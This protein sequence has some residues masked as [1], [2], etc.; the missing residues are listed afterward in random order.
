MTTRSGKE[1]KSPTIAEGMEEI[2]KALME[3]R[4]RYEEDERARRKEEAEERTRREEIEQA[5][6]K[7]E[8]EEQARRVQEER[9]RREEIE[10]ARR[11]E[12]AGERARLEEER[13]IREQQFVLERREMQERME[14]LVRLVK[15]PTETPGGS[16]NPVGLSV[17]LASLSEK[18]DIEAYLVTFER[19]MTAQ[20]VD[21]GRWSQF[22][23]PQLTGRAQLAF[24]ALPSESAA[25]YD[26]IKAAVLA[27][28]DIN[29]EA[30]RKRFR[31]SSRSDGETNREVAVR[32][33]DLLQ[34]WTK[35]CKTV[36]D[37]Q[38]FIGKEQFLET[39]SN[40]EQKLWVMEK[41]PKTSIAAGELA[42]EYEQARQPGLQKARY[43]HQVG[44][45]KPMS[46]TN[47]TP[48]CD[49]CGL[50]GHME[51]EC[52][53]KAST[54]KGGA[55][56]ARLRCFNCK[57][58]GHVSRE[59]PEK[60][61]MCFEEADITQ[62]GPWVAG[63]VE[64]RKVSRILLDTGCTRTMV[65]QQWVP[66]EKIIDGKMVSIRCA[67]G[68]TKL[69]NL[70]DLILHIRGVPVKVEAAVAERLPV[71]V[72]LG[73]DVPELGN[74]IRDRTTKR[75]KAKP[76]WPRQEDVMVVLTRARARQQLE[77]E[78]VRRARQ[79]RSGVR[80][81]AIPE[82]GQEQ[83]RLAG[84]IAE[85]Q[86][87]EATN[88]EA[89]IGPAKR[90]DSTDL[91]QIVLTPDARNEVPGEKGL[92]ISSRDLGRSQQCD[93]SLREGWEK[94]EQSNG[95]NEEFFKRDGLL[96]R[97]WRPPGRSE[98]YEWEQ[99]VLPKQCRKT[100]LELAH[101][102]PMA[103]HQGRDKTRQRI[104]RRFYW[105]SLF[106]DTEMYCKSC[107]VCQK[108][109]KRGV[110]PAPL[111]PLPVISEPFSRVAMDIVGPLP[112]SQA[113]NRYILVVCD[114]AT[115]YPEAIPLRTID[116]EHI[117]E[118]L[119]KLFA[120][121]GVP[122]E[123]L[124]DQGSNFMSQLL[125]ELYRLLGVKAI[126]TSPYHPQ[127]DGL[128]ERFNQ[129]LKGMLRKTAHDG[130]KYWDKQIPYLLFA[131][132]E[133]PQSSTGFSPFE[134]LYGRDVRGPLDIL[135]ETWEASPK[136]EET[137]V[138]HVLETHAQQRLK[139]MADI[140]EENLV[141][142]Q[143]AQ[144]QW[145]DKRARLREFKSGDPVLVLLPTTTD[146]L[147]A[148]WQGPYQVLERKGKV[149]YSVDMHDKRKRTRVFHVNMLK[150]FQV[151][152]EETCFLEEVLQEGVDEIPAWKDDTVGEAH[153]G[154][155]LS[156][157]QT[158]Q[159][160][161]VMDEFQEIFS[162]RPGRTNLMQHHIRTVDACPVRMRPYRLPHAYRETVLQE[163]EEMEQHGIIEQSTSEW[164]SPIVLVK[165]KD[166]TMRVCVDYRRLNAVTQ[167]E[168]YPMPRIDE[169]ID[170]LGKARYIS[171]LDLTKGYWQMPVAV[172]DRPKTA[173]V[174]P[175]GLFQFRVMPF[176]LN[177]APA[178]FQR[179]TDTLVRGCEAF[180]AA[181]LDDVVIYSSTWRGHIEHLRTVLQRIKDAN[182][183]VKLAKC[184]FGMKEC[185][186]LG[187]VVGNGTVRPE[188]NKIGA[189]ESFP[190]P[191]T[192]REVRGFL[193]LTGY[194]RRFIPDYATIALPL[195]DLTRRTSPNVVE[196]NEECTKAFET[197][198]RCLCC[199][200]VLK[201]PDFTQPFVLQTDASDRGAGAVL[202][203]HGADGEEHPVAYY[204]R[205]FLPREE[206]YS[207]VEKE[208]LAIKLAIAAFR[209]YLLGRRFTI[210]TDHRSLEWLDK[211][212]ESNPRLCR[213]SLSLQP[214][215][216]TVEHRP[217][218]ANGNAD[219]LSRWATNKFVVGEEERSVEAQSSMEVN[220]T[221]HTLN[222]GREQ[223][224]FK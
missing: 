182:L 54:S 209:V 184:Q 105:P 210:Q 176:G 146:K 94:A 218:K 124:T 101:D 125:A 45:Q 87:H 186:Y 156:T 80:P 180:A 24:A 214:Y 76:A 65:R 36:D 92:N 204:S 44:T 200:P 50:L 73:T 42:D 23:T 169:I 121:V 7:E 46:Q 56:K 192:K 29:E 160:K 25:D 152:S 99:L 171:T 179:L 164:S 20:K 158:I 68:D 126:R 129:T 208:C 27:R 90:P 170:Q 6:R 199:D 195:T 117:A 150:A 147:T 34:K 155:Q 17:K 40:P 223:P 60:V 93:P 216:Y 173:F 12:E 213:W 135:R 104:L 91:N 194:Y 120:R 48:R 168:A 26:A 39:L 53:K 201:S 175:R 177:G 203:Q 62:S 57:K 18:D 33:M 22:L 15:T 139:E 41:K 9:Q 133:V 185:V 217:G 74:L 196:W 140:V 206:R 72:I 58:Q 69:Y 4:R 75:D 86:R 55:E 32:L 118:E 159:M 49:Y 219:C 190:R 113:G 1:Y 149:T 165:K 167:V 21:K 162:N 88:V 107:R 78:M 161:G 96:Y 128:V 154:E 122:K 116:A 10:Q 136:S 82:D 85:G 19:I 114:Y 31:S 112:R 130:G 109:S 215:L 38:Q 70:A 172:K 11:K 166:G 108:S 191:E 100:V 28:Y 224:L 132:R 110:K 202:S 115:R 151:R 123:I 30:Y 148:Q 145:Y 35:T 153:F 13:K 111:V 174:T 222:V 181:Y 127:T 221:I 141:I 95:P 207:T 84:K 144:K 71:D 103:G 163:L 212:K 67:H 188:T 63:L 220:E 98:E 5:R 3:D 131:Y 64:G 51:K 189:V 77:E 157:E 61:L 211:L 43:G 97:R 187:H 134:L 106:K 14:A 59:C 52:R 198:K 83:L 183:T 89:A 138:S 143:G 197:L 81:N 193:G 79:E 8:A 16:K 2:L 142:R 178:S 66:T 119:I 137:V 37:V 47:L 205:K 102:I